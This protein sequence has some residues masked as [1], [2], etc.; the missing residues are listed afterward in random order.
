MTWSLCHSTPWCHIKMTHGTKWVRII[1]NKFKN[2]LFYVKTKLVNNFNEL[3][4]T[5]WY[6]WYWAGFSAR[7]KKTGKINQFFFNSETSHS[8]GQLFCHLN[9][10]SI[11]CD[12]PSLGMDWERCGHWYNTDTCWSRQVGSNSTHAHGQLCACAWTNVR[13]RKDNCS[14][15]TITCAWHTLRMRMD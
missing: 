12:H 7:E 14:V 11:C 10:E 8:H 3:N 1:K 2:R 6:H 13:M 5:W 4:W 9:Y 15:Y